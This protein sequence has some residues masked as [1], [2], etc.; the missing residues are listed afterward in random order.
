MTRK[1]TAALLITAA[2]STNVA[3]TALGTIFAYPDVLKSPSTTS[4][5]RS[6]PRRG[7]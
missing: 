4:W 1:L 3:F 5:P 2:I 6:S 7:R